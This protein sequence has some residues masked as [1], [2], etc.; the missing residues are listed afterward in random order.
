MQQTGDD[1][2]RQVQNFG[3]TSRG[4]SQGLETLTLVRI[5]ENLH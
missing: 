5:K 1:A 4:I 2:S 3:Q